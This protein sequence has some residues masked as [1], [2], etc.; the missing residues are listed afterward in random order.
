MALAAGH[1]GEARLPG[2]FVDY[3]LSP[4]VY[5][6]SV[7]QTILRVHTRVADLYSDPMDQV[8]QQLRLTVHALRERQEHE[9][10]NN[11]G[12]RP[13]AQRRSQA[14]RPTPVRGLPPLTT[15]T[16]CCPDAGRRTACWPIP[17]D[18]RVRPRV[19]RTRALSGGDRGAGGQGD[20]LAGRAAAT[21]RQD[22]GL[23]RG[24]TSIMA[25]R[26]GQDDQG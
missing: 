9:L 14:A 21:V 13:A 3:D 25:M 4:R 6:L 26:L 24:L 11:R 15:W 18:R 10:V 22:P 23:G 5:E 20:R 8:E 17:G 12:V 7:A 16:S 2:T 19:Q 1:V